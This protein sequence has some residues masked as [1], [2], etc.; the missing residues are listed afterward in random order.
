[1]PDVP[2]PDSLRAALIR[3]RTRYVLISGIEFSTRPAART[4]AS[5]PTPPP[6]WERVFESQGALVFA[7]R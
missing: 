1:L 4:L 2:T 3:E 5:S 7:V 6:G